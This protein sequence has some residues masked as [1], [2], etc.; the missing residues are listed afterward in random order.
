MYCNGELQNVGQRTDPFELDMFNTE[1][2]KVLAQTLSA[3]RERPASRPFAATV[4]SALRTSRICDCS[5]LDGGRKPAQAD[6]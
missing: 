2:D 1:A 3:C 4:R 6:F 5:R